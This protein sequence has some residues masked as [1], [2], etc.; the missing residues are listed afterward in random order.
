MKEDRDREL[1]QVNSINK[2]AEMEN[3]KH[4]VKLKNIDLRNKILLRGIEKI[5]IENLID[6]T[7]SAK[8][9]LKGQDEI[10]MTIAIPKEEF[11][12][13]ISEDEKEYLL[14]NLISRIKITKVLNSNEARN[15]LEIATNEGFLYTNPNISEEEILEFLELKVE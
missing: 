12:D 10:C 8:I 4:L 1:V 3:I 15:E 14:N 5:E 9:K 13:L 7:F 2:M 6:S 11:F